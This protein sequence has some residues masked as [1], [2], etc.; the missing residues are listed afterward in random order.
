MINL[1][2]KETD[3]LLGVLT[4]E[5]LQSLQDELEEEDSE[6][7]DYFINEDTLQMFE[8]DNVDLTLISLLRRALNSSGEIE[9]RW[10]NT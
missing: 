10:A 2:N 4:P 1:Y 7:Q 8:N 3:E 5:Q 9:V 6:D